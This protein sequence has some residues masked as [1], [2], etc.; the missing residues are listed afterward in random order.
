MGVNPCGVS[1]P[2]GSYPLDCGEALQD[3]VD[4][5]VGRSAAENLVPASDGLNKG[6]CFFVVYNSRTH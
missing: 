4:G 2:D 1:Q 6:K 5:H 3:V